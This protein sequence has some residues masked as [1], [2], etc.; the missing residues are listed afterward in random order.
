MSNFVAKERNSTPTLKERWL[1]LKAEEPGVRPRDAAAKLGVT[2]AEFVA[3]RCG[4]GVKRLDGPWGDLIQALSGLG[5]VMA[6]TRNESIVHEKV[7]CFDNISIVQNMGLVV[8]EDIDLRFFLNHWH[9][10]FA[11]SEQERN[12]VRR[13]LQFFDIDGTAVHKVFLRDDSGVA[14]FEALVDKFKNADQS[15]AQW[16]LPKTKPPND[17]PDAEIDRVGLRERWQALQDVHDFYAMLQDL[18]VGRVQAFR[19]V[20]HDVA[21]RVAIDSFR[22]ALVNAAATEMPVMIFVG[23]PGVIQIHTGQVRKL[24]EVGPWYNVVDPGFQLH[25]RQ[26]RI[27]SAWVIKKPT[28]DG[29]VT[30]LEIFDPDNEQIAWMFGKRKPG[31]TERKDWRELVNALEPDGESVP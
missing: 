14:A 6:L 7:G 12:G 25:L 18:G 28:R 5:T 3:A 31:E 2:E 20:G 17:R 1:A 23:N 22:T 10:G 8:N 21:C 24:K 26:D 15:T 4:D 16:V 19:L 30:S 29:I 13:S 27:S 9:S 11:V